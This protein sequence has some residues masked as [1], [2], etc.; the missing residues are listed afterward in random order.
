MAFGNVCWGKGWDGLFLKWQGKTGEPPRKEVKLSPYITLWAT[1]NS[2]W[3]K[4]LSIKRK[5]KILR[6]KSWEEETA[7][8]R[9]HLSRSQSPGTCRPSPS[10]P[11]CRL[12]TSPGPSSDRASVQRINEAKTPGGGSGR[13]HHDAGGSLA[14][15]VGQGQ[16]WQQQAALTGNGGPAEESLLRGQWRCPHQTCTVWES[17][18][19]ACRPAS[20]SSCWLSKPALSAYCWF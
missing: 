14:A 19:A 10:A 13:L 1:V 16:R 7:G 18:C 17:G 15:F 8:G 4:N 20:C 3:V 12:L 6:E 2:R 9:G 5:Q 11:G